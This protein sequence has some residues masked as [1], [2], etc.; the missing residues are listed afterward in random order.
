[1]GSRVNL[2]ETSLVSQRVHGFQNYR[3]RSDSVFKKRKKEKKKKKHKT[4]FKASLI[5]SLHN[6]NPRLWR[7]K[8]ED[9]SE[10]EA[11]LAY[12]TGLVKAT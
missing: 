11:R 7:Q 12:R 8:Q 2:L 3:E 5:Y 9:L 4:K 1:M 10:F 6:F